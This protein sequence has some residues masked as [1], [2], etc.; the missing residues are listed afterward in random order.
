MKQYF[1]KPALIA[2]LAITVAPASLFAQKD[3]DKV[4]DKEN[5]QQIIITRRGDKDEKTVVEIKGDK[6]TVNGKDAS[7]DNDV[8]VR[9]NNMTNTRNR[10]YY[11]SDA[12][13][14]L[15]FEFHDNDFGPGNNTFSIFSEDSNRA[16]LGVTTDDDDKGAKIT[17]ITRESAAS[18]AGLK[19]GDIIT[20]IGDAKIEDANDVT[21]AV[22]SHKPGDKIT[23][24]VLR[25]GKEQKLTAELGKWKGIRIND[26]SATI[27]PVQPMNPME[28]MRGFTYNFN[29]GPK[30]GLSV[31]DTDDG[32]G[33]KVLEVADE[34]AA[35]KAGIKK[36]DVIMEINDDDVNT[37]D[38]VLQAMRDARD[39]PNVK[40]QVQRNGQTQTIEVRIPRKL[41]TADL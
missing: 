38:E 41:K 9:L 30:L 40:M 1:L 7:K 21:E 5:L 18:K 35:A 20:R 33:V 22:H 23:V 8:T 3:K 24:T 32:K 27:A 14:D 16:M 36:D 15:N 29:S 28:P 4:K 31:Q 26:L 34:S 37:T 17:S 12:N 13:P 2:A 25:D 6:V 19:S 11:R 10:V 39:E